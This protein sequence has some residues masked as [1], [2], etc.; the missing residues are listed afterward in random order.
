MRTADFDYPLPHELIAQTPAELRDH[1]RLMVLHRTDGSTEHRRFY[2]I[3]EY[4]RSGDLLVLNDSRVIPARLTGQ[5]R[6]GGMVE[7]LLLRRSEP[8]VWQTLMKPSRRVKPGETI[9]LIDKCR[10]EKGLTSIE[11]LESGEQGL[12]TIRLADEAVLEELGEVPL[13]PYIRDY[14]GDPERYQTV[15]AREKGSVAAPT[16]GLHFTPELLL[17]IKRRGIETAYVTLHVGL[18]SFRPVS[19]EDPRRH[20]IHRE[21]G[22]LT[23]ET[24][25]SINSARARGGRVVCGGTTTARLLEQAAVGNEADDAVVKPFGGWVTLFILP[26]HRFRL[27]D[28]L[29]TNF[30]LPRST[31]LMLVSAF[32]GKELIDRVYQ[33]AIGQRYRFYSFGDAMLIL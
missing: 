32:A 26:G 17:Q 22:E 13:P 11:V 29:I 5:R 21:Y 15:Y 28:S 23:E 2:D 33:E 8:G 4:L 19:E 12:R 30:H 27:V 3:G 10:P 25:A 14:E 1:S 6:S 20:R 24:A 31:L 16:A 9:R 18:D 7:V